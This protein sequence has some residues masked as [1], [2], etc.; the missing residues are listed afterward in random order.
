MSD[1]F[2]PLQENIYQGELQLA[3]S[4]L[5]DF[6]LDNIRKPYNED[7]NHAWYLVGTIYF[8]LFDYSHSLQA[9]RAALKKDPKDYQAAHAIGSC[10]D[11]L[12]RYKMAERFFRKALL[13][14]GGNLVE[15]TYDLGNSLLD[16]N[17]FSE[18][19][20]EYKKV[21]RN[22]KSDESL[23]RMAENNLAIAKKLNRERI[24]RN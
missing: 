12:E 24:N 9:F 1:I 21:I 20:S 22:K 18:A 19:I 15:T 14:H 3:L 5:L 10:Y 16:Q 2:E 4:K 23:L 13:L 7:I 6:D 11:Q 8:K 17:K